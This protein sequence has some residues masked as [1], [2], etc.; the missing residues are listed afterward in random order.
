MRRSSVRR[1]MARFC[2]LP[3]APSSSSQWLPSPKACEAKGT[4][5]GGGRGAGTAA[6]PVS[7]GQVGA[8]L[9]VCQ[10]ERPPAAPTLPAWQRGAPQQTGQRLGGTCTGQGCARRRGPV[11]LQQ[12]AGWGR[13]EAGRKGRKGLRRMCRC[14]HLGGVWV[15]ARLIRDAQGPVGALVLAQ[16]YDPVHLQLLGHVELQLRGERRGGGGGGMWAGEWGVG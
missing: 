2:P 14:V 15:E 12:R 8:G 10:R 11:R 4:C 16:G 13:A 6:V 5:R 9:S 3:V 7:A 1:R